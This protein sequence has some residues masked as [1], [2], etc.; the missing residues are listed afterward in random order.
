MSF[1]HCGKTYIGENPVTKE[2]YVNTK[3]EAFIKITTKGMLATEN[4]TG[5]PIYNNYKKYSES[6]VT[7]ILP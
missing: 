2:K 5:N 6:S 4:R 7:H 1:L 3:G